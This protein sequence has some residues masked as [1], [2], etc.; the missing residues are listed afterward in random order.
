MDNQNYN[1]DGTLTMDECAAF[2]YGGG[3]EYFSFREEG[4]CKG[5]VAG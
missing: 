5:C 4:N 1:L 2:A 3:F